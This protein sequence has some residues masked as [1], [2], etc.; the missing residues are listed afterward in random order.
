MGSKDKGKK[1]HK[2]AKKDAKKAAPATIF[3]PVSEVEVIRKK[4][5]KEEFP[6]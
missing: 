5:K 6:E 3:E 2:K 1:E 4:G